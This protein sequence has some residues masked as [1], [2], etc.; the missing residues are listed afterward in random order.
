MLMSIAAPFDDFA[1]LSRY[2]ING[3]AGTTPHPNRV[4]WRKAHNLP[5][6]DPELAAKFMEATAALSPRTQK[7]TYHA[8]IAWPPE[9]QPSPDIMQ[10]IALQ[11]LEL[12]GLAEHEA[13]IVGHGDTEHPHLHMMINRVNPETGKAWQTSHDWRKFDRIMRQLSETYGFQPTP[14]HAFNPDATED[15]PK[16]STRR[17][18]HAGR[19]G[20]N[21][22]RPQWSRTSARELGER[23]SDRIDQATSWEELDA[24]IAEQGYGLEAKGQGLV[25]GDQASYAKFSSLGLTVSA[26]DCERQFGETFTTY[27]ARTPPPSLFSVSGIDILKGLAAMGLADK[28]DVAKAV[29]ETARAR[30]ERMEGQES[31]STQIARAVKEAT[32]PAWQL[33]KYGDGPDRS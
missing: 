16:Q 1:G 18:H 33:R 14:A 32:K 3:K 4:A 25:V 10:A 26:K 23:I 9:E 20:A 8:M 15:W 7:P 30:A 6:D 29:K 27:R 12:A 11:T 13:L 28:K 19:R 31:L 17:A 21:T 2:L 24:V 22:K 5:T